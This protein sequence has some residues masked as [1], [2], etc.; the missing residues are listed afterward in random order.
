[1]RGNR[2]KSLLCHKI[3]TVSM[4]LILLYKDSNIFNLEQYPTR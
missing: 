2:Y 4:R 1:V 3:N